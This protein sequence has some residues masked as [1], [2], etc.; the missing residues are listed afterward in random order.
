MTCCDHCHRAAPSLPQPSCVHPQA[1]GRAA[2]MVPIPQLGILMG[3]CMGTPAEQSPLCK[4]AANSTCE[5][6]PRAAKSCSLLG[7][8][9]KWPHVNTWSKPP[10]SP[11][12][13]GHF[14]LGQRRE[15][16]NRCPNLRKQTQFVPPLPL[17][18]S[19]GAEH[20]PR[21]G[22]EEHHSSSS[23]PRGFSPA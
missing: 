2:G 7:P 12:P 16:R 18:G 10:I 13:R 11:L 17:K 21:H 9:M 19:L 15:L 8:R 4:V 14:G 6:R 20:R 23:S 3:S 1:Q 5:P 22:F